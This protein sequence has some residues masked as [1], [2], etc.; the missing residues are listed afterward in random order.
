MYHWSDR[1]LRNLE[2]IHP[3]LRKVCDLALQLSEDD[4]IIVE[5][6]RSLE[7]QR[8]YVAEGKS[9]TMNSRHLDGHAVDYAPIVDGKVTWSEDACKAVAD[10]F[11]EAAEQ[12]GIK[13]VWGGDWKGFVDADHIELDRHVYV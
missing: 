5:G 11:K 2:G 3:D 4:F 1:S 9:Q 7:Q 8:I 13:I 6:L 10:A 12:L